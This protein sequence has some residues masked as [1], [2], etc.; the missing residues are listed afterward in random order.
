[1]WPTCVFEHDGELFQPAI[2]VEPDCP[3]I[4]LRPDL[5]DR[6]PSKTRDMR[7]NNSTPETE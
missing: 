6:K 3:M 1:M 5:F 4:L 7:D 2:K